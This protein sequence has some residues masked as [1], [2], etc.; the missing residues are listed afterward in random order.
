MVALPPCVIAV[1]PR[2][3]PVVLMAIVGADVMFSLN[4]AVMIRVSRSRTGRFGLY[5]K[6]TV[7]EVLS[8]VNVVLGPAAGARLPAV[9]EAVPEAMEIPRVPSP[10]ILESVTV[11]VV[12]VPVTPTVALAVPLLLSVM[13]PATSVLE[14]KLVSAYVTV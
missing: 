10:V 13:L 8:T 11:R 2:S 5:V 12:P 14:L 1:A 9:S 4:V 3:A 6:A 7:G